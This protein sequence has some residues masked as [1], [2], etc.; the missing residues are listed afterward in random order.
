MGYG[1]VPTVPYLKNFSS[2]QVMNPLFSNT[3][4]CSSEH[5]RTPTVP[6]GHWLASLLM[7]N[8]STIRD[9]GL[10]C[11]HSNVVTCNHVPFRMALT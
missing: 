3:V 6:S 11:L 7:Q 9:S 4:F 8:A 1:T 2:F 5:T 10:C